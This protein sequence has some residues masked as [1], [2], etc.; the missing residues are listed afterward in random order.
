MAGPARR[1]QIAQATIRVVARHGV[2]GASTARIAKEAGVSE[3]AL[4]RHFGS[5]NE[6]IF[7]AVD[8]WFDAIRQFVEAGQD[9]DPI[10]SLLNVMRGH[11]KYFGSHKPDLSRVFLEFASASPGDG[12]SDH[13]YRQQTEANDR[14]ARMV[15]RGKEQGVIRLDVDPD[16]AA[17]QLVVVLWADQITWAMRPD[18]TVDGQRTIQLYE[19]VV[20]SFR[21]D[22][23]P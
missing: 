1:H 14:L 7:A 18:H 12:V 10:E 21:T 6:I 11:M 22:V 16:Q 9:P 8:A 4:Y 3:G 23:G 15:Q 19:Q 20:R 5:R 2:R 17:W 13:M